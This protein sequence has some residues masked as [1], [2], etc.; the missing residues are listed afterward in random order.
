M[1]RWRRA[2]AAALAAIPLLGPSACARNQ[3][4]VLVGSVRIDPLKLDGETLA[5]LPSGAIVLWRLDAS[6]LF[7]TSFNR[8]VT[9][10]TTNLLPIGPES[11]FVPAR[12]V[13]QITGALYAMQG[14]DFCA[15]LQGNFD[16]AT[17]RAA[18][19]RRART[20]SGIP[21]VRTD[22]AGAEI[23]TVANL[24]F[25]V[26]SAHTILSGDETALRR[27]LDRM[28]FA[29]LEHDL[30]AWMHKILSDG[31]AAFAVVGDVGGQ[32]AVAAAQND[33]PFVAG[34][35]FVR[36]LGNFEPPGANVVGTM[37]YAD[38]PAASFGAERLRNLAQL[39]FIA[40]MF[41]AF[42]FGG[43]APPMKVAQA[44]TDVAFAS[45]FDASM[46]GFLLDMAGQM[47]RPAAR[48]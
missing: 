14:A 37:T 28:R 4:L 9:D 17:I 6:R 1:G 5:L 38:E 16:E 11:N 24:G 47:T 36:V 42:G 12:D 18:A 26:L 46:I 32:A 2:V 33:L 10:L 3:N 34:L 15:V 25:V 29:K 19:A 40:G 41:S 20:P 45:G 21:L 27:A 43:A 23:F 39:N 13:R 44:G 8:S 7:A 31:R 35:R 30:P 48:P 22:Y